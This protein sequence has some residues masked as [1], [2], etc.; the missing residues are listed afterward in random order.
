M[1]INIIEL[2]CNL[3]EIATEK[4]LVPSIYNSEDD[5]FEM[6]ENETERYKEEVQDVFNRHYDFYLEMIENC[7]E[8]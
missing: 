6:D 8:D 4:E 7:M 3:A 1:N 5:L 2:A